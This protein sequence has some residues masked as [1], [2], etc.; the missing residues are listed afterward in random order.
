[1]TSDAKNTVDIKRR[2]AAARSAF[3]EMKALLT[4]LKMPFQLR[5]QILKC[6]ITQILFYGSEIWTLNKM[7]IRKIK[8][9]EMWF[10]R[11]MENV[12]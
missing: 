12:K 2:I 8:V 9:A 7:N 1:M 4:N 10:L 5:Y 11:R 6:Y 3:T